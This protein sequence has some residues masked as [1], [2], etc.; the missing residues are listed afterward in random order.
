VRQKNFDPIINHSIFIMIQGNSIDEV[1][2]EMGV[3]LRQEGFDQQI[4][5]LAF[6]I[7]NLLTA[8]FDRLISILYRMDVSEVKLRQLLSDHPAEDAGKL[9]ANLM[10]ERQVQKIRSR[11][12]FKKTDTDIDE[13]EKW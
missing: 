3:V 1:A 2:K 5:E 9:I 12:Q 6:A 8:N 10:V 4:D 7:N 11:Q 13:N